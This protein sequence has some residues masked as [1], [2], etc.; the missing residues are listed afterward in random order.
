MFREILKILLSLLISEPSPD[1]K[2]QGPGDFLF[3]FERQS[4]PLGRPLDLF[5]SQLLR[6]H[7]DQ[8]MMTESPTLQKSGQWLGAK[9]PIIAHISHFRLM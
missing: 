2:I 4:S 9:I 7:F 5:V 3:H 1:R 6:R 8:V